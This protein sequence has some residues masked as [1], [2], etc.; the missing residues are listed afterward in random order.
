[1]PVGGV[2]GV[3]TMPAFQKEGH[4]TAVLK[5][6]AEY[7]RDQLNLPFGLLFC[8]PALVP[9]YRRLDW[10]LLADTVNIQQPHGTISSPIPVMYASFSKLPWPKGT[11]NL[12]SEPW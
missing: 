9:F 11:V 7:L 6:L 3:I 10:Q 1:V 2:G 4:A 5:Y 12:N 8:R